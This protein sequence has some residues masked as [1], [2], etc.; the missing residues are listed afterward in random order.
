MYFKV[1]K[2]TETFDKLT[3]LRLKIIDANSKAKKLIKELGGNADRIYN[4]YRNIGGGIAAIYFADKPEGWKQVGEN[5]QSIFM[6]KANMKKVWDKINALPVVEHEELNKIV[7]WPDSLQVGTGGNAL[8]VYYSPGISWHKD[9]CLL[10]IPGHVKIKIPE[11]VIEL[12][13]SEYEKHCKN[14]LSL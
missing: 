7:G 9:Y 6:P 5:H 12:L 2:G 10:T 3:Q 1:P 4:K 11:G 8:T 14:M 13:E